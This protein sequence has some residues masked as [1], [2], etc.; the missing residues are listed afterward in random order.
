VLAANE[1]ALDLFGVEDLAGRSLQPFLPLG[2]LLS[3]AGAH[4]EIRLDGR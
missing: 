2:G 3:H 4:M 1:L